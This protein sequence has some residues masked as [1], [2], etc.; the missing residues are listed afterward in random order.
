MESQ[1]KEGRAMDVASNVRG[2]FIRLTV[3]DD[4]SEA[5]PVWIH[6]LHVISVQ[7]TGP[8]R[9]FYLGQKAFVEC[10]PNLRLDVT[11]DEKTIL[12]R[13]EW[14]TKVRVDG[15]ASLTLATVFHGVGRTA[16]EHAAAAMLRQGKAGETGE[17]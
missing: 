16:L 17:G 13:L 10:A 1:E 14:A 6:A 12:S 3:I 11:E 8:G 7:S 9:G 2:S 5:G 4:R 15:L